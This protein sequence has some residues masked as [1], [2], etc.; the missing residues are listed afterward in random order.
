MLRHPDSL[1]SELA[2]YAASLRHIPALLAAIA[3]T[4]AFLAPVILTLEQG[5]APASP[6]AS[7]TR[8]VI[9]LHMTESK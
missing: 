4:M 9:A 8:Q 7:E 3:A 2:A 5:E 1:K 6:N